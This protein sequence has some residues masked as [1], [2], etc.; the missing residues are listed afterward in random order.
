MVNNNKP[1]MTSCRLF[2]LSMFA[3]S[4]FVATPVSSSIIGN[5]L[6]VQQSC[7]AESKTQGKTLFSNQY[8]QYRIPAIVACKSGQFIAFADHRYDNKDIGGGRHIDIVVRTSKNNGKNWSVPEQ[9][10]AQG[11]TQ[12][13]S[14]FDCAHGDAA[15]VV[16]RETGEVLVMCASGGIGFWESTR[17]NPLMI[18]RYYSKDE[19]EAWYGEDAT[20]EIYAEMPDINQAFFSSGRICQSSKIKAGTHYRLYSAMTTLKGNRVLY[21]DDFGKHW[22]L[23]GV[24]AADAAPMGDEAK[25]EELPDGSVLISSR[26]PGGRLFNI[27]R[28]SD[29]KKTFGFW[30]AAVYSYVGNKGVEASNN[31]CNGEILLAKAKKKGKKV[32]LLLQS[33]PLGPGRS[34]VAIYYKRLK[35]E[36]DYATPAAIAKDW[37]GCYEV[38]DTTSAY[39][40]MVQGQDGDILFLYEENAFRR[41]PE[42]EP[43]DYYDIQFKKLSI[44]EITNNLYR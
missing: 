40:T 9:I 35:S 30:D 22:R 16:D 17:K 8:A 12:V 24:N 3:A 43:D 4:L 36:A 2:C 20:A 1:K 11:G 41:H 33:V 34:H 27:F 19:G 7:V 6:P 28:Y 18:G 5:P 23:L 44:K 39:S 42:K 13:A 37:E 15:A 10:M 25:I 29:T 14:D 31:A 26:Y 32:N 21:S 38:S